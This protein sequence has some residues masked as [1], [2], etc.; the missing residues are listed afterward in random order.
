MLLWAVKDQGNVSSFLK[1]LIDSFWLHW[2]FVAPRW[3]S[4]VVVSRGYTLT[5]VLGLLTVVAFLSA[6]GAR[7]SVAAAR[8]L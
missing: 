8:G 2:A 3:L 7:A 6:E 5:V 4:L 1:L